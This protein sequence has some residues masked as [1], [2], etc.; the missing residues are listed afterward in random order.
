M[1]SLHRGHC[2]LPPLPRAIYNPPPSAEQHRRLLLGPPRIPTA[3]PRKL[4]NQLDI[5]GGNVS[6]RTMILAGPNKTMQ[7]PFLILHLSDAHIGN[8]KYELDSFEV[9]ESLFDDLRTM[10][11]Q[12]ARPPNLIVFNG[13]LV[14]GEISDAALS[15]Q[16][17]QA[18]KW[19]DR[20]YQAIGSNP[21]ESPSLRPGQSRHKQAQD[22]G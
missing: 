18:R 3:R 19:L 21:T 8:P 11:T 14:Y 1:R 5:K 9:F 4:L 22:H 13:D 20:I 10:R 17:D 12:L 7:T 6:I 2:R 16:Y 15:D